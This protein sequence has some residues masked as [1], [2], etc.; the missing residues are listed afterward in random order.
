MIEER[1]GVSK[2]PNF[3][4]NWSEGMYGI[5]L[6]RTS[7]S[8]IRRQ[9]QNLTQNP[10]GTKVTGINVAYLACICMS[11]KPLFWKIPSGIISE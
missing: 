1:L 5:L 10:A 3:R 7:S 9:P 8:D 11:F 4:W 6:W 2:S